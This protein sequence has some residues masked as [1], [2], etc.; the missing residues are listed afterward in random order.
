LDTYRSPLHTQLF[1]KRHKSY[2]YLSAFFEQN[3]AE[4]TEKKTIFGEKNGKFLKQ[5]L[6][7]EDG[8]VD[9]LNDFVFK[10][11]GKNAPQTVASLK[12]QQWIANRGLDINLIPQYNLTS[13][14]SEE[15]DTIPYQS[16]HKK[17]STYFKSSPITSLYTHF[18]KIEYP[19][20]PELNKNLSFFSLQPILPILPNPD[21][22]STFT[23]FRQNFFPNHLPLH[24]PPSFTLPMIQRDP[25][26]RDVFK[27]TELDIKSAWKRYEIPHLLRAFFN[28]S[29]PTC[30]I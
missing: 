14:L 18:G 27:C 13:L 26:R 24:T 25:L 6:G 7:S 8:L 3:N 29:S 5:F 17:L 1:N 16:F 2:S 21:S 10:N 15:I 28:K 12:L 11:D 19:Q 22:A 9:L 30:S 20:I 4:K 23:H